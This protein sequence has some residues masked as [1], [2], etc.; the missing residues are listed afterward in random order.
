[1][2]TPAAA[3]AARVCGIVVDRLCQ[4]KIRDERA[5]KAAPTTLCLVTGPR[6]LG[7]MRLWL[8][9]DKRGESGFVLLR[10][11][12]DRPV[13]DPRQPVTYRRGVVA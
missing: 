6:L 13:T 8:R 7:D 5:H 1:M 4:E 12:D 2:R 9:A 11:P 10:T 3:S